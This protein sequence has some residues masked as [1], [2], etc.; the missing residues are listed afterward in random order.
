MLKL[1]FMVL[2]VF[3]LGVHGLLLALFLK[4][5]T[6]PVAMFYLPYP[7]AVKTAVVALFFTF[8]VLF[9]IQYLIDMYVSGENAAWDIALKIP[10]FLFVQS[11]TYYYTVVHPERGHISF[12]KS[13]WISF[14]LTLLSLPLWIAG[15]PTYDP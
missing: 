6:R 13:L 10:I 5:V 8:T 1:G 7:K 3:M 15:C 14:M 4:I 2:W 12:I 9:P 11:V